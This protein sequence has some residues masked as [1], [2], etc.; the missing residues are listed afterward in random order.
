M[1]KADTE[2][3][4]CALDMLVYGGASSDAYNTV[5]L[6]I[7][8]NRV[9]DMIQLLHISG[10]NHVAFC[11]DCQKYLLSKNVNETICAYD[12][13]GH[14]DSHGVLKIGIVEEVTPV[15]NC[16]ELIKFITHNENW[17]I[18]R[19][20]DDTSF[21]FFLHET[22]SLGNDEIALLQS[23]GGFGGIMFDKNCLC[24]IVVKANLTYKD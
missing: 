10:M 23:M 20:E 8:S 13:I 6:S 7:S 16:S 22:Y 2:K 1:P 21:Q 24:I 11:V 4:R 15:Y 17:D 3:V 18:S 14:S 19:T 9:K 5:R 12:T